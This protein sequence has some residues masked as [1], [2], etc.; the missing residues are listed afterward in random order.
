MKDRILVTGM[1]AVCGTGRDPEALLDAI[2]NGRSAI[3]PIKGWDTTG[4]PVTCAAEIADFNARSI[5]VDR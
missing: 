3:A 1:G 2:V 4:C 5:V